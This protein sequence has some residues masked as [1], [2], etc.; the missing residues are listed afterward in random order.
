M[1]LNGIFFCESRATGLASFPCF[2]KKYVINPNAT[3]TMTTPRPTNTGF[4][5]EIKMVQNRYKL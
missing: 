5:K 4:Y 1:S 3:V 2:L